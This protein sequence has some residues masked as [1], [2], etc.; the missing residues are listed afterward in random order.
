MS[1]KF[2]NKDIIKCCEICNFSIYKL[3]DTE[4][5][6]KKKGPVNTTD[7]CKAFK[8]N[9]LKRTPKSVNVDKNYTE[10]DFIL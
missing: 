1:K 8:Y 4:L 7:F 6:C 2:F 9:P 5:L 10:K 3:S